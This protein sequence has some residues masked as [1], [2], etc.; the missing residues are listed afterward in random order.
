MSRKQEKLHFRHGGRVENSK[1]CISAVA[2]E[3][4]TGKIAFPPRRMSR[5]QEKLHFRHGG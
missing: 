1:N 3:Q 2:D 5:K 4:K